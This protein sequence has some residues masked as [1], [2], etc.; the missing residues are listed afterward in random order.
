[1]ANKLKIKKLQ[2]NFTD[3][4]LYTLIVFFSLVVI[5]V[6]VYAATPNPGHDITQIAEPSGCAA[7]QFL[8]WTGVVWT[9]AD[10][11][12]GGIDGSGTA[13][14][15]SK[16]T[17]ATTVGNSIIY[18][19]ADNVGIGT[20]NPT[21]KLDVDG[22]V[23]ANAFIGDGSGLMNI[24]VRVTSTNDVCSGDNDGILR[25]RSSYCSA[26]DQRRS[27]FDI[28]MRQGDS[29]YTWYTLRTY[30]WFDATCDADGCPGQTYYECT[31]DYV[32]PG[33]YDSEPENCYESEPP[34]P[35]P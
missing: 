18:E 24:I 23:K 12:A 20:T 35:L 4:W 14:Y 1:M 6:F 8:Q 10:A 30:Y 32:D 28:C 26:D 29:S 19:T 3:R 11:A 25:Y 22:V 5:G 33:C 9:C 31:G 21:R 34:F 7:N 16:F 17:A 13:N 2:I 15:I 27:S